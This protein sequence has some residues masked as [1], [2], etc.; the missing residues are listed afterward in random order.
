MMGYAQLQYAGLAV[1]VFFF[2][3]ALLVAVAFPIVVLC[4]SA[5]PL[6]PKRQ[7]MDN[8]HFLF[9][10]LNI[11]QRNI[12]SQPMHTHTYVHMYVHTYVMH[13]I[14][15]YMVAMSPAFM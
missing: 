3:V 15:Y 4:E 12:P 5:V 8:T 11:P 1:S 6:E 13:V 14:V 9:P 2:W 10:I 7:W